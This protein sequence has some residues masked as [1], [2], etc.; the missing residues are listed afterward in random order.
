M[1]KQKGTPDMGEQAREVD[2][3]DQLARELVQVAV[4]ELDK[5]LQR[6]DPSIDISPT[7]D[8]VLVALIPE[9]FASKGGLVIAVGDKPRWRGMVLA[10]GPKVNE[11]VSDDGLP[12]LVVQRGDVIIVD[13]VTG[14]QIPHMAADSVGLDL[15]LIQV[16]DVLAIL[17]GELEI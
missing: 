14:H 9:E 7:R 17:G 12:N 2:T 6:L 13:G 4:Q 11:Q 15:R 16:S 1:L 10:V 8:R 3:I 5:A